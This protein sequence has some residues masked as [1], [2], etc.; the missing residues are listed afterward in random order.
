MHGH[1]C[2]D[3]RCREEESSDGEEKKKETEQGKKKES[4]RVKERTETERASLGASF[5]AIA[6]LFP[7]Q[8]SSSSGSLVLSPPLCFLC[9]QTTI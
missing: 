5:F 1:A 2:T 9:P 6:L 4:V 7:T 3:G 8:Q